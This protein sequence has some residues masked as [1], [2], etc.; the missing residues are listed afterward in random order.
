MITALL[1]QLLSRSRTP[2]ICYRLRNIV[3]V[4]TNFFVLLLDSS[5]SSYNKDLDDSQA[6]D[7]LH[8]IPLAS[9]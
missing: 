7:I 4:R 9:L 3:V 8:E 2:L 5:A 1:L 6:M